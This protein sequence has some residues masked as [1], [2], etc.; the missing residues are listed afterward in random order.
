[1][2]E[3]AATAG[4]AVDRAAHAGEGL[5]R[6][7]GKIFASFINWLADSIAPPPPPTRDQAERMA[8]SAEEK[9]EARAQHEAQRARQH[10]F[11][12]RE[13]ERSR[14]SRRARGQPPPSFTA[15]PSRTRRNGTRESGIEITSASDSTSAVRDTV[16]G[17]KNRTI[18]GLFKAA[19]KAITQRDDDAP[20]PSK[21]RRGE[22]EGGGPIMMRLF[23]RPAG[24]PA[25]RGRYAKLQA[26]AAAQKFAARRAASPSRVVVSVRYARLAETLAGQRRPLA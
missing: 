21:R 25:A 16:E 5:L 8:R 10:E 2:H 18:K 23:A 15:H 11:I 24:R 7:L 19:I 13:I 1:M 14:Q 9:Q 6:G 3:L 22:K 12:L 17:S 20:Q 4:A 26:G